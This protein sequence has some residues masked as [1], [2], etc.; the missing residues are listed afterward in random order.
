M[1]FVQRFVLCVWLSLPFVSIGGNDGYMN[2]HNIT[3]D[4]MRNGDGLR[5]VLWVAG[6]EHHCKGCQNPIT[7]NPNGGITFDN[8]A[9]EEL[10]AELSKDYISGITFSGGD[11][12][13]PF[14][15]AMI[16]NL[17]A[18]VKNKYP[19]K[20]V[21]IYTGYIWE[22]VKGLAL[23]QHVD[24]LVDGPFIQELADVNYHWAGS[25]NQRV[26]DVQKSL[27]EGKVVLYDTPE[28]L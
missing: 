28:R 3:T 22:T 13:F 14:N 17:V 23:M 2:Y 16:S 11:P 4:D 5:V 25:T 24:V 9:R 27:L 6:C 15:R 7:W 10:F 19:A 12:L 8:E 20:T 18:I 26:I 21:W 1:L